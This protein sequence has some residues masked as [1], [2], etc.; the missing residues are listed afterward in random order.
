MGIKRFKPTS[1]SLRKMAVLSSDGLTKTVE[2]LK[3][4]MAKKPKQLVETLLVESL[5]EEEV[6]DI[7]RST[8]LSISKDRKLIS[9]QLL[10]LSTTIQIEHVISHYWLMPMVRKHIFWLQMVLL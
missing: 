10:R 3:R 1:P 9:L 2:P 8:E 7:S 5:Q 4:F 6:V